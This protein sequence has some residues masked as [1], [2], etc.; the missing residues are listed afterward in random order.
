MKTDLSAEEL[1]KAG[2]GITYSDFTMLDNTF[3]DIGKE[4]ISL[5]T[6]LGKNIELQIPIIAS[7]MDT[8][9]NAEVC[10]ALA[11]EGGI[12]VIHY[13][14]KDA[15]GDSDVNAQIK[16]IEKVKRFQNGFIE[17][18]VTISPENTIAEA[19]EK[20][21]LFRTGKNVID[22][23]PV[24]ENGLPDGK[25]VG[26]LRKS[27]Y[28]RTQ[29]TDLKV[30]ERMV[31]LEKIVV[32]KGDLTL[33]EANDILWNKHVPYLPIID[34]NQ[35]L[36]YLVTQ[37]DIEKNEKYPLATKDEFQK[38]RVLFAVE[39]WEEKA[40]DRLEK[41]FAAGAD[42]VVV[43][44]SQ[45]F[46]K[47]SKEMLTYI[48]NKFPEKL[49]IGGNISTVE[50][51][52]FLREIGVDSFRC[53]QGP[54]S[55]CTTAGAIGISRAAASSIYW[56]AKALNDYDFINSPKTIADGGIKEVGD[57]TKALGIGAHAVMLGN[58]LAGSEEGHGEVIP[59]PETGI[60]YKVY[61]GMGSKEANVG[62]IRG[63][64]KLPQGISGRVRY[65]GSIH[66]WIPLIVDGLTSSFQVMNCKSIKDIHDKLYNNTLR[67][68][69]RTVGSIKE[70]GVHDIS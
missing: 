45:G 65:K 18:P 57:I 56:S 33:D 63:Y 39:T 41:G 51:A 62:E 11:Q 27:D 54:G 13:N 43:D 16:E 47:F 44:T 9:T 34:E 20:G 42:G 59:N 21:K 48:K 37:S 49:L 7:P 6:N 55:I 60:P 8:V 10:I 66:E 30:K 29:F 70:S 28:R 1:F 36:K 52:L 58:M 15:L 25:L 2:E 64:S 68:E 32:G 31:S 38:L 50:A 35:H 22:T 26:L 61:R 14:Q 19:I 53:G 12:G 69:K 67:F 5:K 3:T 24:T 23:F 17:D 4:Q 46:T 40:Y